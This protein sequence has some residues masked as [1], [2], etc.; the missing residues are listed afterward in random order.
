MQTLA[1]A[2]GKSRRAVTYLLDDLQRLGLLENGKLAGFKGT[3]WRALNLNAL[4]QKT[5]AQ[6]SADAQ[7]S[8]PTVAQSTEDSC[9]IYAPA[10]AQ[11][12]RVEDCVTAE[13]CAEPSFTNRPK[14]QTDLQTGALPGWVGRLFF[15]HNQ[16][17]PQLRKDDRLQFMAAI[18]QH[19]EVIV[20]AAWREF[21]KTGW[22]NAETKFPAYVFFKDG[23]ADL[24]IQAAIRK[25][26][27]E[28]ERNDPA[29]IAAVEEASVQRQKEEHWQLWTK[30]PKPEN[31]GDVLAYLAELDARQDRTI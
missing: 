30:A 29:R 20:A 7:S 1:D 28:R 14:Q 15:D 9:A 5:V 25:L 31:G 11:P 17:T 12:T 2:L 21:V 24:Y 26:K 6:S 23:A 3:R 13:D 16:Q 18:K 19:G 4:A 27:L 10:V 22:Y 8:A